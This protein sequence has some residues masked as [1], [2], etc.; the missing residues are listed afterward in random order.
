MDK[1]EEQRRQ[2]VLRTFVD[3]AG[4]LRTFPAR[5]AKRLVVLAH[6]AEAFEPGVRYPED[7]VNEMLRPFHPDVA[8]LRRYL[9]DE[10]L[11]RRTPGVYWRGESP[12][13]VS[14]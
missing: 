13:H 5:R 3:D 8:A 7:Q 10:G 1:T 4:A 2:Q 14:A 12:A 11:L 6:V 9:V